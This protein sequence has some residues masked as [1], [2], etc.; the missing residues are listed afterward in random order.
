M[1]YSIRLVLESCL[2]SPFSVKVVAGVHRLLDELLRHDERAERR[3]GVVVLLHEPVGPPPILRSPRPP[4]RRRRTRS[5]SRRCSRPSLTDT[6]LAGLPTTTRE[7]ALP[8]DLYAPLGITTSSLAPTTTLGDF[9]NRYGLSGA[10]RP[11]DA[12]RGPARN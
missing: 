12:P 10:C 8:V 9:R 7:L 1:L 2:I 3:E 6:F 11:R 5:C 4:G